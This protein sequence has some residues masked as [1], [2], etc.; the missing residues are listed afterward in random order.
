LD[1]ELREIRLNVEALVAL[2][3]A[4][5]EVLVPRRSG[6]LLNVASTASFQPGPR[7]ATYSATKAFVRSFTEAIHEE[8]LPW[9][10]HV[11]ALCPG[12]T[13]TEFQVS[14]G[15]KQT[16]VPTYMWTSAEAVAKSGL[17]AL[18]R[19]QA[20]CIPG[21]VNKLGAQGVRLAPRS[22]ARKLAGRVLREM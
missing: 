12:F 10:I 4:T 3:H 21:L 2:S 14:A 15:M 6:N 20:V 5:L 9:G 17:N 1:Q 18:E 7:N 13:P 11:T 22:V 16:G 19:N 8:V